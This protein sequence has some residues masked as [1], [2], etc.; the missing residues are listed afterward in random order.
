MLKDLMHFE[1]NET[2]TIVQDDIVFRKP[3]KNFLERGNIA[4]PINSQ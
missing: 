3:F 4:I 2:E 1:F